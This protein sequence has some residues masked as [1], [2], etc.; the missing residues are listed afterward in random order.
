MITLRHDTF[1]NPDVQQVLDATLRSLRRPEATGFRRAFLDTL[2]ALP[3]WSLTGQYL[4]QVGAYKADLRR[5][6]EV[7]ERITRG[8][9]YRE[10]HYPI[11][12]NIQV[13]GYVLNEGFKPHLKVLAELSRVCQFAIE[14]KKRVIG[15]N[16]FAYWF[17]TVPDNPNAG[18]VAMLFYRKVVALGFFAPPLLGSRTESEA[19]VRC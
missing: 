3:C 5:M 19:P 17:H 6:S 16:V 15:A 13:K 8:I 14:G 9:F 4:G 12:R 7:I 10:S 2:E 18:V 1:E 11:P